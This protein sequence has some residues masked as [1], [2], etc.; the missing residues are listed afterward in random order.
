M[1]YRPQNQVPEA[2]YKHRHKDRKKHKRKIKHDSGDGHISKHH[3]RRSE[4]GV[5]PVTNHMDNWPTLPPLQQANVEAAPQH[6]GETPTVQELADPTSVTRLLSDTWPEVNAVRNG[7]NQLQP[8]TS[9]YSV[10]LDEDQLVH[11]L[12]WVNLSEYRHSFF[13]SDS[14]ELDQLLNLPDPW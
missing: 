7:D 6:S 1:F 5:F 2:D 13:P 11:V 14:T 10:G 4:S 8:M 9:L 3:R 12:P